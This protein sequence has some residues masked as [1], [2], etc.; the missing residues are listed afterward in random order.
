MRKIFYNLTITSL[1]VAV[2]VLVGGIETLGLLQEKLG[3]VGG[4]W[5][6]V[7]GLNENFGLLGYGIIALFIFGWLASMAIYKLR[8][9]DEV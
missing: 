8:R 5:D 7:A 1:S 4:F 9:Y 3:L 2:A 6:G